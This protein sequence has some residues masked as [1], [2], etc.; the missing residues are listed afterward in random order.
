MAAKKPNA[1]LARIEAR[2]REELRITRLFALQQAEDIMILAAN[3]AFGAGAERVE[4]FL[5]IYHDIFLEYATMLDEDY[6]SDRKIEYTKAKVD[7]RLQEI[8]KD[9]YVP[10]ENRYYMLNGV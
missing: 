5:N 4:R 7:A 1:M 10:R 3:E 6:Q 9:Y 2:H 8:Q